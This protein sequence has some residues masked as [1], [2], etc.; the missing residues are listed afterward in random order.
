MDSLKRLLLIGT[1]AL[2]VSACFDVFGPSQR[3]VSLNIVPL[4]D[5]FAAATVASNADQLRIIIERDSSG[6]F[7]LV[8]DTVLAIDPVTGTA[9]ADIP[10]VLLENVQ[11]FRV[12]LEAFR[13]SDGEIFFVGESFVTVFA[14]ANV[15][16]PAQAVTIPIEY[17]G[18]RG[19]RVVIAPRDTA[20]QQGG[21]LT[22]RATVFD[23]TDVPIEAPVTFN[24][25]TPR[26]SV[27]LRVGRTTGIAE[28]NASG[29]GRVSVFVRTGDSLTD[30]TSVFVV[31]ANDPVALR[32][33]TGSANVQRDSSVALDA[34][35][36][37]QNGIVVA[38]D[39]GWTSRSTNIAT[40]DPTGLVTG[41]IPGTAIVVASAQ[42][43]TDSLLVTV[44]GEGQV[45][46]STITQGRSFHTTQTGNQ[47]VVDLVADMSFSTELLGSYHATLAWN[48]LV[49]SFVA[50]ETGDFAAPEF[51][52]ANA[53]QGE[54]RIAQVNSSG[55]GGGPVVLA[56]IRFNA[57]GSGTTDAAAAISEMSAAISFTDLLSNVTVTNGTVTVN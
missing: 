3:H 48:P 11:D 4:F 19:V 31:G 20:V 1:A 40:V 50:I 52:D 51:N 55:A 5:E 43:F 53:A 24:L 37:D 45:V 21:T 13:A 2:A 36:L 6:T 46:V 26:D 28:A 39:I 33:G 14:T 15:D 34:D 10:I 41:R 7:L 18:P 32:L 49:L 8:K 12:R 42:D 17:A 25:V 38:G 44:A 47:V 16:D 35:L 22:L 29:S 56:R 54:L 57:V 23:S 30:T 9:A 27:L